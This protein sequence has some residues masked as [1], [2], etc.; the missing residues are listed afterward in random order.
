MAAFQALVYLQTSRGH[1]L[2]TPELELAQV[3]KGKKAFLANENHRHKGMEACLD[4]C[5]FLHFYTIHVKLC[6]C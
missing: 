4:N 1:S 2:L 3:V 6:L 5:N